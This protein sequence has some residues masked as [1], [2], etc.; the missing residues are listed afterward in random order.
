MRSFKYYLIA[1]VFGLFFVACNDSAQ[2]SQ[3]GE[4][5]E[6]HDES[7]EGHDHAEHGTTEKDKSGPEYTSKYICPMHCEGSGSDKPGEC[8]KCGMDYKL[9]EEG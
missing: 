8:P 1:C 7:H 3:N 6:M 2:T 5:A 9:N 4:N